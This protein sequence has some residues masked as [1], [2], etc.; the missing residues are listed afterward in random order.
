MS[1][2]AN[3][4]KGF[5]LAGSAFTAFSAQA[6]SDG[7]MSATGAQQ[8][9]PSSPGSASTAATPQEA[10]DIIVTAQR[11]SERLQDVPVAVTA[12]SP[13]SAQQL[14]LRNLRDIKLVVPGA[15][16]SEGTGFAQLYICLLYTSPSPRDS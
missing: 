9:A 14:G 16:F 3:I 12:V 11:R 7:A 13:E 10:G 4:L 8:S 15:D 6:Q 1:K 2:N 5:L